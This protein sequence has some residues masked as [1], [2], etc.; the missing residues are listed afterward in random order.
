MYIFLMKEHWETQQMKAKLK[1]QQKYLEEEQ[2]LNQ[3]Q[4]EKEKEKLR[5][6]QVMN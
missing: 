4:L 6:S 5:I 1:I 3:Y 2:K